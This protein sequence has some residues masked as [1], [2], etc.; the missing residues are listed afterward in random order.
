MKTR[1]LLIFSIVSAVA[2]SLIDGCKKSDTTTPTVPNIVM[3]TIQVSGVTDVSATCGGLIA[4]DGGST[5]TARGVCWGTGT[6][7][8]VAD[9]KT[10]DG[11]GAGSFIS[12]MPGLTPNTTYFVRAYATNSLGTAY[13]STM[14]FKTKY[15]TVT[16]FDGNVYHTIGIGNQLWLVENLLV[17]HYC[18]GDPINNVVDDYEWSIQTAGAWCDYYNMFSD[19]GRLYNFYAVA[20]A[21]K[22]CPPG[23][24]VPTNAEW[25]ALT[26][27]LGGELVAGGKMKDLYNWYS[28]NAGAT[29]ESGFTAEPAGL[30]ME[31]SGSWAFYGLNYTTSLWSSSVAAA[32]SAISLSLNNNYADVLKYRDVKT[33][34]ESVRCI[35]TQAR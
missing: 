6:T 27:F 10:L 15:G 28:P 32:D 19:Y 11:A 20:D 5:I 34:G 24:H 4:S 1:I 18:N 22:L 2:A 13:G 7:P 25:T 31:L 30:R 17:T 23:W 21:R 29:N 8:T 14:S 35:K 9:T 26:T 12:T 3:E 33:A 16:D